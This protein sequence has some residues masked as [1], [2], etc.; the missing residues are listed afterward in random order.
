MRWGIDSMKFC[1]VLFLASAA[2]GQL[3]TN[4]ILVAASRTMASIPDQATLSV[5]VYSG[6]GASLSDVV[7]AVSSAGISSSNFTGFGF[8]NVLA[9]NTSLEWNFSLTVPLSTLGPTMAALS[10]LQTKGSNGLVVSF[11]FQ[12]TSTSQAAQPKCVTSDL[13]ADATVQAQ[14]LAAAANL[15]LG[16]VLAVSDQD[17]GGTPYFIFGGVSLREFAYLLTTTPATCAATVKFGI[18]RL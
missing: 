4:S 10:S 14:A 15:R 13:V 1:A 18:V 17:G 7:N 12:G 11:S 16:P 2:L 9:P 6:F 8:F 3:Q 5:Q